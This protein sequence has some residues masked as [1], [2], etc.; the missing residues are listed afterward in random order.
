MP[1]CFTLG[2][3]VEEWFF[4]DENQTN[5]DAWI[6]ECRKALGEK[7]EKTV[8]VET[9]TTEKLIQPMIIVPL[10]NSDCAVDWNYNQHGHD[11]QCRCSE[12]KQ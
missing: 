3:G 4:C 6:C 8:G 7:C 9:V 10:P 1:G 2:D 11:W 12:G 5:A